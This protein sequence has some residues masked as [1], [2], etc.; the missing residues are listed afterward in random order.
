MSDDHDDSLDRTQK[1]GG[2]ET[3]PDRLGGDLDAALMLLDRQVLDC[4]G[5]MVAK[6][7]DLEISEDDDGGLAISAIL[8]GSAAL[9]PRLGGPAGGAVYELWRDMGRQDAQRGVPGWI[10]LADVDRL[11]SSVHLRAQRDGVIVP[12]PGGGAGRHRLGALLGLPVHRDGRRVGKVIDVRLAGRRADVADR[13]RLAA[14]VVGRGRPGGRL[15]YD[16]HPDQ[17]PRLISVV[18]HA[19]HRHQ[20]LVRIEDAHID[21]EGERVEITTDPEPLRS[22]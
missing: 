15:G 5:K 19:L 18:V 11:D 2:G 17:G 10:D 12:Q 1:D 22:V 7:D 16:R 13:A 8:T 9:V 21:W 14:L 20:G 3:R 4:D 6:V